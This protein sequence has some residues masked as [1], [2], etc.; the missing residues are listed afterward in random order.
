M[1]REPELLVVGAGPAGLGA[2][3][4][5]TRAGVRTLLLDAGESAG[6]QIYAGGPGGSWDEG[7]PSGPPA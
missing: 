5:A 2:A 7:L 6:G 4:E 1:D 3:S